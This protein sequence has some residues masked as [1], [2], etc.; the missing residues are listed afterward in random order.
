MNSKVKVLIVEDEFIVAEEISEILKLRNYEVIGTSSNAAEALHKV[1]INKP[2]VIL[3]DINIDGKMDGIQT[4]QKI[5]E[6]HND[7]AIIYLTAYSDESHLARAKETNPAAY[8]VKPFDERNL[9]IAIDLAFTNLQESNTWDNNT[10]NEDL[11]YLLQ[12]RIYIKNK[13][14]YV[15]LL[16]QDI[17]YIEAI[18]SYCEIV[19]ADKKYT[20]SF[21][22]KHLSNK[23]SH[24]L[25]CRVHRSFIIN[26][27]KIDTFQGNKIFIGEKDISIG[28]SYRDKFSQHFNIL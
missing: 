4:A 6:K 14:R 15:K 13:D 1:A 2:D 21:N 25:L 19:T 11:P 7:I 9:L 10:I 8:I 27:E 23:F 26:I 24:K 28:S 16:I 17:L 18:G 5:R 12:D 20:F 22:L 3:L